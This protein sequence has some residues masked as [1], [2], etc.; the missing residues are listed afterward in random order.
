MEGRKPK[1][2]N[3]EMTRE[4]AERLQKEWTCD[5]VII[6]TDDGY[7]LYD[8]RMFFDIF[9]DKRLYSDRRV[10]QTLLDRFTRAVFEDLLDDG[11]PV[12]FDRIGARFQRFVERTFPVV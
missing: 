3:K 8:L 10:D 6:I 9:G 4:E 11:Q 7:E 12:A 2:E 1:G 5:S